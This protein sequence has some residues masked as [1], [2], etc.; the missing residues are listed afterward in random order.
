[1]HSHYCNQIIKYTFKDKKKLFVKLSVQRIKL[2]RRQWPTDARFK[3]ILMLLWIFS[4][5]LKNK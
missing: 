4:R 2:N 3:D 1:M 5:F